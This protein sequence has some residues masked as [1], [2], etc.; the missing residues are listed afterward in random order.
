MRRDF[1]SAR[2]LTH[3]SIAQP[4]HALRAVFVVVCQDMARESLLLVNAESWSSELD[5]VVDELIRLVVGD[6]IRGLLASDFKAPL[7]FH[8]VGEGRARQGRRDD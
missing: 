3:L 2:N 6:A 1:M 7:D 4:V 5:V 8:G